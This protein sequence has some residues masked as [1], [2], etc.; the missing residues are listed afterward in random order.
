MVFH[1]KNNLLVGG[2]ALD[3]WF[4]PTPSGKWINS[5]SWEIGRFGGNTNPTIVPSYREYSF[6]VAQG[7]LMWNFAVTMF[8]EPSVGSTMYSTE[9]LLVKWSEKQ[10]S[11]DNIVA[12][13]HSLHICSQQERKTVDNLVYHGYLQAFSRETSLPVPRVK[14]YSMGEQW[15]PHLLPPSVP[16]SSDNLHKIK[17]Q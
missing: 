8:I 17:R 5:F 2:S 10:I 7:L 9:G 14:S 4:V 6:Q 12:R 15:A 11:A 13:S 3:E 16:D 1:G